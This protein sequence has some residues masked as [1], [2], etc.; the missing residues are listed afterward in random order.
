MAVAVSFEDVWSDGRRLYAVGTLAF[1]GNYAAGGD[2]VDIKAANPN[3]KGQ[4]WMANSD[5]D[6]VMIQG[7]AG[8]V[9]AYDKATKKVQVFVNTAGGVNTALGEHTAVAYVAGIT[10]DVV[11]FL[12][13]GKKLV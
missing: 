7:K 5:P 3:T 6:V 8:F 1:S 4:R 2:A 10:G 11:R 9:Y 13:I 12:A